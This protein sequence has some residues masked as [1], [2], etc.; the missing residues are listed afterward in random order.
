MDTL[1]LKNLRFEAY[2]GFYEKERRQGNQFE[3]DL[4]FTAD[5]R[6]AGKSD[7]LEDTIDYQRAAKIVQ[8]VMEG[9][10]RKLIETLARQIGD[11]LFE[12]FPQAEQLQV[13]VRKVSPPLNVETAYSETRMSWQRSS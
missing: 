8:E 12:S 11:Q 13:A 9:P 10:S 7:C 6:Q 1:T 3:V 2:H 5:L 4:T